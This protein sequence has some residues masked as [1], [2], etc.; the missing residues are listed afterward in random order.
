MK[1]ISGPKGRRLAL[2]NNQTL[3][4]GETAQVKLGQTQVKIRCLEVRESSAVIVLDGSKERKELH[5]QGS[6]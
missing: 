5:L 6:L 1:G 4:E 3:G 2:I